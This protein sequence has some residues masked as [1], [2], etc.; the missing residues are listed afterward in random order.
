MDEE[1][2]SLMENDFWNVIP[3][4]TGRNIVAYRVVYK[5]KGNDDREI[6]QYSARLVAK[7]FSQ[8]SGQD[9]DEIF[10]PIVHYDSLGLL[11]AISACEVCCP[12]QLDV[13]TTFFYVGYCR[14]KYS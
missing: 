7:G 1:L 5:A 9:H 8:I 3:K 4:P 10:A 12:C 14:K 2:K 6:K 11:L 13:E